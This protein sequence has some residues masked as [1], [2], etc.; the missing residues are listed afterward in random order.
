MST[1][2]EFI[3]DLAKMDTYGEHPIH[4]NEEKI[5]E[6][7]EQLRPLE[8]EVRSDIMEAVE[9]CSE[10]GERSDALNYYLYEYAYSNNMTFE[11][12]RFWQISNW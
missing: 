2:Q 4:P 11:Y 5:R 12:G 3:N 10:T 1:R 8:E 9:I 6:L 7:Y